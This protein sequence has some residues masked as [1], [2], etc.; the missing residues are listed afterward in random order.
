MDHTTGRLVPIES[1]RRGIG[2]DSEALDITLERQE[3][4]GDEALGVGRGEV[5]VLN[6]LSCL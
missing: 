4:R 3:S 2:D 1:R 5:S 6:V